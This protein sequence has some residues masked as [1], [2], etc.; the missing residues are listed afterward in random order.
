[1]A[2]YTSDVDS[3]TAVAGEALTAGNLATIADD[4]LAYKACAAAGA[5]M[6]PAWFVVECDVAEGKVAELKH[7]G[8][9][10]DLSGL[11]PGEYVY[12]GNTAGAIST[13]AGATSQR[14]GF[15]NSA[16]E[17]TLEFEFVTANHA[18]QS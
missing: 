11:T 16:T 15:A 13:T 12:T 17:I 14:V 4:G 18:A 7:S 6:L 3:R 8:C 1:M 10:A 5:E 9:V 2:I